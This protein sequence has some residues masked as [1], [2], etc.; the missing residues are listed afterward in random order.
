MKKLIKMFVVVFVT[1][2]MFTIQVNGQSQVI[3]KQLVSNQTSINEL[4]TTLKG[5]NDDENL[6]EFIITLEK[7]SSEISQNQTLSNS[8]V[9]IQKLSSEE[10]V[11]ILDNT[12]FSISKFNDGRYN[13]ILN[14]L[15]NLCKQY[16]GSSYEQ[17]RENIQ[18]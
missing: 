5:L 7:L 15:D 13:D 9:E 14:K 12:M 6:T 17:I 16:E 3:D 2:I 11:S 4:I 8:K 10:I 18:E 1:M